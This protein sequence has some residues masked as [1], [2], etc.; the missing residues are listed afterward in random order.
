M[1]KREHMHQEAMGKKE[2]DILNEM[3]G[4]GKTNQLL[5]V[6]VLLMLLVLTRKDILY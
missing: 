2:E 1:S 6:R 5:F 3:D 4:I